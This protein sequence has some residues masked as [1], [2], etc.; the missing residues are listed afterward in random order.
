LAS[1]VARFARL[2]SPITFLE[3]VKGKKSGESA[4]LPT[5]TP[6]SSAASRV[7]D[8]FRSVFVLLHQRKSTGGRLVESGRPSA[9]AEKVARELCHLTLRQATT[10]LSQ[11]FRCLVDGVGGF[12]EV[13]W[14]E[15]H[16]V[17]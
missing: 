3:H 4:S 14:A 15:E 5:D 1:R 8:S 13:E 16:S 6:G 2:L 17:L 9:N 10:R 12:W 11:N 7:H